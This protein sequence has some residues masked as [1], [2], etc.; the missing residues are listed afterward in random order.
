MRGYSEQAPSL[1]VKST[2]SGPDSTPYSCV[3]LGYISLL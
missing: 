2:G 1:E 3:S